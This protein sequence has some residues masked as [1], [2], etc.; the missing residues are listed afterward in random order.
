MP[1]PARTSDLPV[2]ALLV[3]P[4]LEHVAED[5]VA[6]AARERSA[7]ARNSSARATVT[8]DAL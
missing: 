2:Q 1:L 6:R 3:R 7:L 8:G 5:R 4:E